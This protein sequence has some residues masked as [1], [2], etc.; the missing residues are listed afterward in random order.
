VNQSLRCEF[1]GLPPGVTLLVG[2]ALITIHAVVHITADVRV[3]EIGRV[4]AA[5][6][7]RALENQ[8]VRRIDMA[9]SAH[10]IGVPVIHGEISMIEC[11]ASPGCRGVASRTS[12]RETG[13][14]VGRIRCGVVRGRVATVA[15]GWQR[16]VIVVYVAH[17][18]GNRRRGVKASQREN[19]R[20]VIEHRAEEG[21]RRVAKGAIRRERRSNVVRYCAP[22][23]RGALPGSDV[24]TVAGCRSRGQCVVVAY[25][26]GNA[27]RRRGGNV[28]SR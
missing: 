8:V 21:R 18:T 9:R 28:H 20:V 11:C 22:E 5:V 27:G 19:R 12:C 15:I 10:P 25:V 2:M 13:C 6:A 17:R 16:R 24:A 1:T 23:R 26:T 3:A 4:P 14:R 7:L